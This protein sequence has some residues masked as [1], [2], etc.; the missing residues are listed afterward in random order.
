MAA[1]DAGK[2]TMKALLTLIAS[3]ALLLFV[4]LAHATNG[5]AFVS[6]SVPTTMTAGQTYSVSV[7]MKNTG[8]SFWTSIAN[9]RLGAYNPQDNTTWGMNRVALPGK[10]FPGNSVTFSF[11]VTAPST[12]GTYNFQWNMV[13]DGVEWFGTPTDNV[14]ITVSGSG[15]PASAVFVTSDTGT[16]GNWKGVYGSDGDAIEGD[17]QSPPGYASFGVSGASAATWDAAPTDARA[18]QRA[19]SG[20]IAATW[21]SGSNVG[22][23]YSVNVNMTDGA[24]HQL[25]V[26]ALDWDNTGRLMTLEVHDASSGSLLDSRTVSAFGGGQW[27]VW[28]ITGAV[29]IKAIN[30]VTGQNAVISAVMFDPPGTT[31]SKL[32]TNGGFESGTTANGGFDYTPSYQEPWVFTGGAG[33][34]AANSGFT[35]GNT[36]PPQGRL[37]AFVQSGGS[38]TQTGNVATPGNY[39]IAFR[40]VD[41][42]ATD[43]NCQQ[44][45]QVSVDGTQV[46]Y[47]V[48]FLASEW[49][50][51]NTQSFALTAGSHS[52]TFTG[53]TSQDCTAFI[54]DV[55]LLPAVSYSPTTILGSFEEWQIGARNVFYTPG[56][57]PWNFPGGAG[58]VT[59][60]S[61]YASGIPEGQQAAFVID[62]NSISQS[63]TDAGGVYQI[64]LQAA[65]WA[66]TQ[67]LAVNIDGNNVGYFYLPSTGFSTFTTSSFTLTPG[68]HTVA[69][70]PYS[71]YGNGLG[72]FVDDVQLKYQGPA[73]AG[74]SAGGFNAFESAT[75]AGAV[76][77]VIHT[78][79]A[80]SAFT[81]DVVALNT[82]SSAVLTTFTGDVKVE[83]LDASDNSGA[84]SGSCRSSW[85]PI[86]GTATTL[87]FAGG[88]AGRKTVNLT[89][90]NAWRDVR[91][92]MSSPATGSATT[93]AC[94]NDDFAI[95][96]SSFASFAATDAD[97][98][99]AGTTR[100]LNTVASTGGNVHKAGQPFTVR[101]T[102]VNALGATT[103]NYAGTPNNSVS[104][105]PI[106]SC[107]APPGTLTLSAQASSGV[108]DR[109]ATYSEAGSFALR[110]I[111]T[112]FASVDATDGSSSAEMTIASPLLIVGRF[113]P[114]H[115]DLVSLAAPVLETF[116]TTNCAT[117]TFT[118]LGQPFG[119]ASAPRATLLAK[120]AAG[121]T[122]ANYSGTR[123]PLSA[124]SV[125]QSHAPT[126]ASPALDVSGISAPTL[127]SNGDGTGIIAGSAGDSLRFTRPAAP[128][129]LFNA[130]I[131]LT[132]SVQD[133][134]EAGVSGNGTINTTTPLV[135][136]NIAFDSGSEFRFGLLHLTPAYGSEL[137]K[138]P[139]P[140]EARY[141]DGVRWA[142]NTA[143]QCTALS[144]TA[145][146][147]G[148]YQ[149]NLVACT[150]AITAGTATLVNGR[151]TLTLAK[152][153]S[154]YSGSVDLT[155]Q[156]GASASGQT[157]STVGGAAASATA[158]SLPWLLGGATFDQN[159]STRA[160]FGQY[161]SPL[162]FNRENY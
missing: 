122:T 75:A 152:P 143:D 88:D 100:T 93:V 120:N 37:A 26:Y 9:Y 42:F 142:T 36:G 112:T 94:S 114:D 80:G 34:T 153:G 149:K 8:T 95:R 87:T 154:G 131:A 17:S 84:F 31:A 126:P 70:V 61:A 22:D 106:I 25:A 86:G 90:P 13:Q 78:K 58:L 54:D 48:A 46:Q 121:A 69:I 147:M 125:S 140:L 156:L 136:S 28:N 53:Q 96:P 40:M 150:T 82:D 91:V 158:A 102:A 83:L 29:T 19:G 30:Q 89:E 12:P 135:F 63:W 72:V 162:I 59:A 111:D 5:A 119:Y 68:T 108:I 77:G 144:T 18:P 35:N 161:H 2:G 127:T 104:A 76:S 138:L 109:S 110:L 124:G 33:V 62:G 159:P 14:A 56:Q 44:S 132:W 105:C 50:H 146:A 117:R 92:R 23:S 16:Q 115:F 27:V 32:I 66:A 133:A 128:I 157:C 151:T 51:G 116:G 71:E 38:I 49:V 64:Q 97:W 141:W 107:F 10:V 24:T 47:A 11:N 139:V 4:P 6:Q 134:S 65:I 123:W 73:P 79:I 57:M 15:T 103:T 130:N 145:I 45:L 160:S 113:V 1:A 118:Y 99:S 20:R 41:R 7:T 74:G 3:V 129:A 52:V 98:G 39:F 101:A 43:S 81:I 60:T 85:A 67:Y 155:L 21:Y 148:N 137:L 55:Q